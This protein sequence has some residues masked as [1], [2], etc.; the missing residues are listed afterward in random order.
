MTKN[1]ELRVGFLQEKTQIL[2]FDIHT[3]QSLINHE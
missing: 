2:L 1:Q 3:M